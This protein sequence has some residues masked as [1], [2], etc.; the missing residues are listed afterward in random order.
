MQA[1]W[2]ERRGPA[3][4]VLVVGD[5]PRPDPGPGEVRIR[6]ACSGINPGDVKK[7]SGWQGSTMPFPRVIPHSDGAGVIDAVGAGVPPSR[8]GEAAWCYGAQSYRPFGTAAEHVVVPAGLAVALPAG[9]ASDPGLM[10]QA[11]CLGIAG[12]T[13]YRSVFAA[14]PV[15]GLDVLVWGAASGVGAVALQMAH[16]SGARVQ[17]VVRRPEQ[18]AVVQ[19]MG[20]AGAWL[21][22]DPA[23]TEQIRSIAPEGVHRIADVDFAAHIDANAAVIA[24]GGAIGAYYSSAER[25]EIPYWKLAFADVSLRLLGSDDFPAAVKAEAALALTAAL[26]E[27][28]LHA[29]IGARLPLPD[30]AEAHERVERGAGGRVLLILDR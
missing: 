10:E 18:R 7:R 19:A 17:A 21:A 28:R 9:A 26:V 5:M 29:A 1:A 16:R 30:I 8:L 20:A 3:R 24:I 6:L 22:D 12:I 13:G 25:P 27:G 23:L 14:G 4:E 15:T 2:Y 11:A